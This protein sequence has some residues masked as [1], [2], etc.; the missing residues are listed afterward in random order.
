MQVTLDGQPFA[1]ALSAEAPLEAL[2][3]EVR[4]T[5]GDRLIVAVAIN[6]QMLE[7][8][9]LERVLAAPVAAGVTVELQS[10]RPRQ[11]ALDA[12][13]GLALELGDAP[14]A[15]HAAAERLAAGQTSAGVQD[16]GSHLAL[17]QT[18]HQALQ[19][20][21]QLLGENLLARQ[22]DGRTL[23]SAFEEVVGELSALRDTLEARDMVRLADTLRYELPELCTR[24][25]TTLHAVADEVA[26]AEDAA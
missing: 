7:A 3:D 14:A 24:W 11:L 2:L 4:P 18:L 19:Q 26:A 12:L 23:Q 13:R 1:S 16:V 17:W 9:D 10:A 20:C 25:Q 8:P 5:V 6:G 21:S 22:H 15:L